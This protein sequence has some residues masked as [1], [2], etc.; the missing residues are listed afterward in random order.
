MSTPAV[1]P[2][3]EP[4]AWPATIGAVL[5]AGAD[6]PAAV[7]AALEGAFARTGAAGVQLVEW[8]RERPSPIAGVGRMI[9]L[10]ARPAAELSTVA[11]R[12][13]VTTAVDAYR[14]VVAMGE[15]GGPGFP[16]E[17]IEIL[18]ATATLLRHAAE[19]GRKEASETL[20]RLSME[21]VGSLDMDRVLLTIANAAAR[22]VTSEVA[23][24]FL[25]HAAEYPGGTGS[26][27]GAGGAEAGGGPGAELRMQ[28]VVGHRTVETAR[29][30]IPSGRGIAGKVLA[31]GRPER[32]DDYVTTTAITMDFL[33]TAIQEGTQSG[34]SVPM[35]DASGA[36]IGVLA[37]WRRRPSVYSDEDEA[38]LVSLAGLAA[39]GLVN[40]RL[41]QQQQRTSDELEAHRR[42]LERRLA[43]S[44][45]ALGIHR[46]LT[47]IAAE[48]LDLTSLAEAVAG[49][50]GGRVVIVPD[51]DRPAVQWPAGAGEVPRER[52]ARPVRDTLRAGAE[53][54]EGGWVSVGIEAANV[55]HGLLFAHLP[56]APTPR[57]VVTLE[58]SATICA[59]LLGHEDS[60]QAATAR[61][62]SEF[63]W[64]LLEGRMSSETDEAGRALALGLRL[65]FPARIVLLRARGLRALGRAEGWSAE[66]AE[67][68]RSWLAARVGGA[69]GELTRQVVHVA[70]RDEQLVAILP[71]PVP[72]RSPADLTKAA[73]RRSPFPS[74]PI[75]AG[76]SR[77]ALDAESLPQALHE[78]K[79]ALSAVTPSSG[80]VVSFD[81]LGVLQFLIAPSGAAD[82]YRYAQGILGPLVDYDS[83]HGTDLVAT[84]DCYFEQG[85]NAS[86]TAR[87]L[88]LHAKSLTYRLRRIAE[89]GGLDLDDR[90]TR[91]DVELALRILGPASDIRS[92]V[93][94]GPPD[95]ASPG[96]RGVPSG[97]ASPSPQGGA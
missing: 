71:D 85:A 91:L 45:E 3:P 10:A 9:R 58:Q 28:C 60:L 12:P 74:V 36:I 17:S 97:T 34:L 8:V 83:R 14:D 84:L 75:E 66:E 51:G 39:I 90:Q 89:I 6:G 53:P 19:V 62:R 44:D 79:V 31:S 64:D 81:D 15:L 56:A 7:V 82:L 29:L 50:V 24:V 68:G 41:Y 80:P 61:L 70:H 23:G 92:R 77:A 86:K 40:A 4:A 67:R 2:G 88:Q 57:D 72:G 95:T 32:I 76:I 93:G 48:G 25:T 96:L 20:H 87:A 42:E 37:V 21:I 16:R 13:V 38:L 49:F 63:V 55:R 18:R 47:E 54:A 94:T 59:L 22:L 52:D 33:G 5:G 30:R 26:A 1:E 27:P 73:L 69:Y 43:V 78:A 46:R 11:G 65:A 35:F